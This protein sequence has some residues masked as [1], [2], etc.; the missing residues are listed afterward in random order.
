MTEE[1]SQ[2]VGL[3]GFILAGLVFV[4]VGVRS[5]DLLTV[6]GSVLWIVSCLIWMIPL[7]R[8]KER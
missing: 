2:L 6:L 7:V 3:L 1:R 4:A 5:D 8:P